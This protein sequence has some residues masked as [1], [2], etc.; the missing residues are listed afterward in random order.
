MKKAL[1]FLFVSSLS[2]AQDYA[3]IDKIQ[4]SDETLPAYLAEKFIPGYKFVKNNYP[5]PTVYY[6]YLPNSTPES[7]VQEYIKGGYNPN[8]IRLNYNVEDGYYTFESMFGDCDLVWK[9]WTKY[10]Q[11]EPKER[12][13]R[14]GYT[15]TNKE[16]RIIYQ[17]GDNASGCTI[18]NVYSKYGKYEARD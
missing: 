7:K 9:V 5:L 10:I 16:K 8:E 6:L 2:F 17:F 15:F 18:Y 13:P 14:E 1:L 11:P 4:S 3:F 12:K